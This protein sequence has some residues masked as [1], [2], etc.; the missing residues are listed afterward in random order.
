MKDNF[1]LLKTSAGHASTFHHAIVFFIGK[2]GKKLGLDSF[3]INLHM[4][5][6]KNYLNVVITT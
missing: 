4:D 2:I 1:A 3:H 6:Q 5:L